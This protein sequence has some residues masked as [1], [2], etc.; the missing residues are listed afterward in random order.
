MKDTGQCVLT[1]A[2]PTVETSKKDH[3]RLTSTPPPSQG[4]P[5][6]APAR[7]PRGACVSIGPGNWSYRDVVQGEPARIPTCHGAGAGAQP[8]APARPLRR[9]P[10]LCSRGRW[11][12]P[13]SPLARDLVAWPHGRPPAP[14][15]ATEAAHGRVAPPP[16]RDRSLLLPYSP[17]VSCPVLTPTPS[18]PVPELCPPCSARSHPAPDE[19]RALGTRSAV[20]RALIRARP[21]GTRVPGRAFCSEAGPEE[22][23][24]PREAS[25]PARD[26]PFL[27]PVGQPGPGS[28]EDA[29]S[30][31]SA[32]RLCPV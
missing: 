22:A 21:H 16:P 5:A 23:R 14:A 8:P 30:W 24:G 32:S 9:V 6:S 4:L 25:R 19:D 11:A 31:A 15:S 28:T 10:V 27:A 3:G 7:A 18:R 26:H 17:A 1:L 20:T 12:G 13:H 2:N 29:P